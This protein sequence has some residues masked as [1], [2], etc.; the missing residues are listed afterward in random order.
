MRRYLL[1]VFPAIAMLLAVACGS[2]NGE[3][4]AGPEAAEQPTPAPTVRPDRLPLIEGPA[5]PGGFKAILGTA[6]LGVGR[7][8]MGFVLVS[9]KG[10]VTEPQVSVSSAFYATDEAEGQPGEVTSGVYQPWPYGQRGMYTAWLDFHSA[11][12]WGI[13]IGLSVGDGSEETA[14]LFFQVEQSPAA[15]AVGAPAVS[16]KTKTVAD[17][18]SPEDLATGSLHDP[19]L[20]QTSLDDALSSGLP[21]VVVFASP[22]FCANA[23]CGPQAET[24]Q[25]IKNAYKGRANFIH[26]DFYDNPEEIQG[27]LDRARISPVVLDWRLPSIEWTFVID[28][29]GTITARFEAFATLDEVERAFLETL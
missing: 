26:V 24:L 12:R 15:P 29:Q 23:V 5:S 28:R 10:F 3:T 1:S 2:G 25:Q 7:N 18:G 8:R 17:V 14:K 21:T 27:D 11:G 6:D 19:D 20:Y 22:A 16:S 4:S 9:P 13:D